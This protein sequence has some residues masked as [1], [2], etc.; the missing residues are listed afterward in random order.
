APIQTVRWQKRLW[1]SLP[2]GDKSR[3]LPPWWNLP[4]PPRRQGE[5]SASPRPCA[6]T[7]SAARPRPR[8]ARPDKSLRNAPADLTI[9]PE[10][11]TR[12]DA[13]SAVGWNRAADLRF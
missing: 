13:V 3:N 5:N 7:S 12:S 6:K 4:R 1:R 8:D 2:Q 11:S 10:L 9:P